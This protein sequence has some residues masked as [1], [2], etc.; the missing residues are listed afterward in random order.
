M[1]L[2]FFAAALGAALTFATGAQ[3]ERLTDQPLV[4]AAWLKAHL[5]DK[6]LVVIDIRDAD[7][8]GNPYDKGHVPGAVNA[9]Y[10]TA[11]WRAEVNGVPGMLPAVDQISKT[12]GALGISNDSHVV[13]V[14]NG[15]DS[16]EFGGAT[17]VYW[18]F[19]VLGHDAVSILDGGERGWEAAGGELSTEAA[20]PA[21]ASFTGELR[22]ELLATTADVEQA[23]AEGTKLVDGRPAAQFKGEA[24]SPVV[25]IAGTIPGA[26][27]LEN[28]KLYDTNKASFASKE[29]VA[30]LSNAVGLG[31]DEKNIAFC[32]TGHWA[33]VVWF[34]LSEIEGNKNTKMYDGSMAEWAADPERPVQPGS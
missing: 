22:K 25:R 34:G 12:I 23:R 7:K 28:S 6:S 14:P 10:S 16:S 24:K 15:T 20:K 3:A 33:S 2:S 18:T 30:K 26:V 8:E 1:R 5:G 31:N 27:N 4:D 32:N 13:I 9:P 29:E 17:R 21:P 19:K 11:G